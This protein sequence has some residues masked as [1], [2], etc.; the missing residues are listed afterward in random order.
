MMCSPNGSANTGPLPRPN[1]PQGTFN[2]WLG[3]G[4]GPV[5]L[6]RAGWLYRLI[7]NP[8]ADPRPWR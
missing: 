5:L 2:G 6:E 3:Q 4:S 7:K 8:Q 1:H